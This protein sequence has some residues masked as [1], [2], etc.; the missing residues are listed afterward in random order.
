M[1][2]DAVAWFVDICGITHV[3]FKLSF[4][5]P[6]KEDWNKTVHFYTKHGKVYLVRK[7]QTALEPNNY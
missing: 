4:Q 2:W 3:V 6:Q 1:I 5:K 7:F